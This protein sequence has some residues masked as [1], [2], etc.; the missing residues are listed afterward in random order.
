MNEAL[1][2]YHGKKITVAGFFDRFS[3]VPLKGRPITTA[4]FLSVHLAGSDEVLMDRTYVEYADNLDAF[5]LQ[6]GEHV[7]FDAVVLDYLKIDYRTGSKQ[8]KFGL[9]HPTNVKLLDRQSE[10]A[11]PQSFGYGVFDDQE[12]D[13]LVAGLA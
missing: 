7:G 5:D 4:K 3:S 1:A 8:Q 12:A 6:R 2:R 10:P 11:A 13:D 9:Y